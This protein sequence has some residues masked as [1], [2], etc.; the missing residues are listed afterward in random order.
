MKSKRR[1]DFWKV[2]NATENKTKDNEVG[3]NSLSAL[4]KKHQPSRQWY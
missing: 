3:L 1:K 2:I 4:N